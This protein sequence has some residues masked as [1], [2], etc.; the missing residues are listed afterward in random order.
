MALNIL[1][2]IMY[3]IDKEDAISHD[4]LLCVKDG[5]LKETPIGRGVSIWLS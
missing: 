2:Q 3:Y 1:H 4:V 5:E